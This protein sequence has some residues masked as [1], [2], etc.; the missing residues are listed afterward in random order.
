MKKLI[1]G[2]LSASMLLTM[3]AAAATMEGTISDSHCGAKH[4][5]A[6]AAD[7]KC[8][9]GCVKKGADPVLISEGKVYKIDASSKS[10]AE[11]YL[12]KKVTV[13]G[14]AE[15]DT[16]TIESIKASD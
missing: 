9:N 1:Y 10:K 12:G 6:T 8:V 7:A 3:S 15:G 5:A 11:E 13:E 2:F 4:S 14:N 16:V